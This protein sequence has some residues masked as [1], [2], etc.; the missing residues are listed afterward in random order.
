MESIPNDFNLIKIEEFKA[1]LK[2]KQSLNDLYLLDLRNEESF[3]KNGILGSI[4]CNLKDL[5]NQY[6]KILPDK[7][8]EI[9][10]YCN[11]GIQSIYG[12]MFLFLKGYKNVKSLAGGFS[13]Y[14]QS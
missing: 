2:N 7:R 1:K 14:L 6:K 13:K 5:P 12:V 8:K 11:G 4:H 10:L 9:I 3:N